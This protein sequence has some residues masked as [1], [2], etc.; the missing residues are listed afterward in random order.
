MVP[1]MGGISVNHNPAVIPIVTGAVVSDG[2]HCTPHPATTA[3]CVA[4]WSMDAPITIHTMMHSTGIV[5]LS[6]TCHFSNRC[7]L[8]RGCSLFSNSHHTAHETEPRKPCHVQD[9]QPPINPTISRLLS[10]RI[11]LQILLQV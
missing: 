8:D 7:H 10:S 5:A 4:L 3:A 11:P 2:T 9:L 1:D 6:C